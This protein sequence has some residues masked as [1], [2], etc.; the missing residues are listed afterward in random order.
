MAPGGPN[1]VA[2]ELAVT[3]QSA[4][5]SAYPVHDCGDLGKDENLRA[6]GFFTDLDQYE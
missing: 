1:R 6:F 5:I 4:G 3:V 2:S